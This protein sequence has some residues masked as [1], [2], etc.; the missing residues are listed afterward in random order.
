MQPAP[1]ITIESKSKY[2]ISEFFLEEFYK[3][4]PNF[5]C[6]RLLSF[7]SNYYKYIVDIINYV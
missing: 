4:A 1:I 2:Q 5:V 7:Y 6:N 3:V